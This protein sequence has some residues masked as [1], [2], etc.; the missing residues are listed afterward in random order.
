MNLEVRPKNLQGWE[1]QGW[2]QINAHRNDAL[3]MLWHVDI[4]LLKD[5]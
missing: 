1:Y 5:S 3:Y 2:L 4:K